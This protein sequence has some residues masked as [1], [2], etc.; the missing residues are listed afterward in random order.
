MLTGYRFADSGMLSIRLT[1]TI[2]SQVNE[3]SSPS[4]RTPD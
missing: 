3:N 4:T 1:Y 2:V